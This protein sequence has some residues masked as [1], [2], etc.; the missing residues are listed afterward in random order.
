M[1]NNQ[2][3]SAANV[4]LLAIVILALLTW[5]YT[6][7]P[8][9]PDA[10]QEVA[11]QAQASSAATSIL[12]R[13]LAATPTPTVSQLSTIRRE[14]EEQLVLDQAKAV[15]GNESLRAASSEKAERDKQAEEALAHL[16]FTGPARWFLAAVVVLV[17]VLGG[18]KLVLSATRA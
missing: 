3:G 1:P 7:S 15:T 8:A 4:L 14:V 18:I 11:K 2:C 16:L 17:C 10:V 5:G 9:S 13:S 12:K 6:A